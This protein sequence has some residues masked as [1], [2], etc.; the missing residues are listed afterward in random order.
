MRTLRLRRL[1][2]VFVV[3][4]GIMIVRLF[5]LQIIEHDQWMETARNSRTGKSSIPFRRGRI[6]DRNGF[7][8]A[9]DHQ[10]YDL[11][12]R[13]RDFRRGF[14]AAQLFEALR[15]VSYPNEG[16]VDC[17]NR[18]EELGD[19]CLALR[20]Q[21]LLALSGRQRSDLR[22]Y[23]GVLTGKTTS[24][25]Q[26]QIQDWDRD[27][28]LS[29]A[30]SF[31]GAREI[32]HQ[33]LRE[34]RHNLQFLEDLLHSENPLHLLQRLENRRRELDVMVARA[35]LQEA[36]SRV[37]D[38]TASSLRNR[39]AHADSTREALLLELQ[40]H[41]Q[42][43]GGLAHFGVLLAPLPASARVD[44]SSD[45]QAFVDFQELQAAEQLAVFEAL[46][47]HL[48]ED[49]PDEVSGAK[50]KQTKVIHNLRV[51]RLERDL[52]FDLVDLLAQ[53]SSD[54]QGLYLQEVTQRIYPNEV[55]RM[56]VGS[57]SL[58]ST[59]DLEREQEQRQR[60]DD[61]RR[62]LHRSA[63]E[64][65]E[66]RQL[67]DWLWSDSLA[68]NECNGQDGI[69]KVYEPVLRGSRGYLQELEGGADGS[70]PLELLFSPPQN[71][72]DI[73]LSLDAGMI[74]AA[75]ASIAKVYAA[76]VARLKE[77]QPPNMNKALRQF[78]PTEQKVGF[79]IMDLHS[80]AVP[81]LVSTPQVT[82][83]ELRRNY[84]ELVAIAEQ[85]NASPLRNRVFGGSFY[86]K[87]QPYP[88]STFKPLIAAAALS[89]DPNAWNRRYIC[90]SIFTPPGTN[91]AIS[92]DSQYGH[93]E[94]D[95]R[96][97]LMKSCNIYFYQ[98]GN[99][100]GAAAMHDLAAQLGF[101]D[102]TSTIQGKIYVGANIG[103]GNEL[104]SEGSLEHNVNYLAPLSIL[105]GD[106]LKRMRTAIGQDGVRASPLQMAR[107]FGWLASG[108]LVRPQLVLEGGGAS[109]A[110]EPL[111][112]PNIS[113]QTRERIAAALSAVVYEEGG[114]A[115][116]TEFPAAW[117]IV[118]KT[119]T[120]QIAGD[121]PTHAWFTGFFP[122]DHPHYSFAILCENTG[123]HGGQIATYILKDF[124]ATPEGAEL[125]R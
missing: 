80:G 57:L 45:Q 8:L 117:Q 90:E 51:L 23:L 17:L 91:H 56:V 108:E 125:L 116:R 99:D 44:G 18:G 36:A 19:I 58:P 66:F 47:N 94:I 89:L 92:C 76:T 96:E 72:T 73:K 63:A 31:P 101:D 38:C 2:Q 65:A 15:L 32:L 95:M 83:S 34:A 114:T 79:V 27:G 20:P 48:Q 77:Q 26:V 103:T 68:A 4:V 42:L 109:P 123:L 37:V 62:L 12:F 82:R 11:Y 61:L 1:A 43:Q 50:H 22:F 100:I 104:S 13:Y 70:L 39:L 113:L 85:G 71:G 122:A 5:Q 102:T 111:M 88:G 112:Q 40:E 124:L 75:E 59:V 87:E 110:R 33:K 120:A 121:I 54:F 105:E 115:Y 52:D 49:F 41:W 6:L 7:V 16:L 14:V 106:V 46:L 55:A 29:F 81:V 74:R 118:G 67:R 107:L 25:W 21:D 84:A 78:Q 93:G 64:E 35:T 86:G 53:Q 30:Q 97:A 24:A 119:G 9:T 69:E 10:A 28:Q 3:L 60:F 98:L